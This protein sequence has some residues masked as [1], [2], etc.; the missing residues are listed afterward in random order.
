MDKHKRDI[1]KYFSK[2]AEYWRLI[3]DEKNQHNSMLRLEMNNR[4][5]YVLNLINKYRNTGQVRLLDIGSGSGG[6]LSDLLGQ[7]DIKPVSSDISMSK[8]SD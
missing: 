7:V 2:R 6:I 1:Q 3:Y 4:K 5:N 8:C